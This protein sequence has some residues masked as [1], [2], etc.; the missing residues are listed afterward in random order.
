MSSDIE[1]LLANSEEIQKR[2]NPS[3]MDSSFVKSYLISGLLTVGVL[4]LAFMPVDLGF[5]KLYLLVLLVV[6]AAIVLKSEIQRNFIKYYITSQQVIEKRGIL[7]QTTESTMYENITD[8]KL[9]EAINER[10][11]DVGDIKV[12]TAG[13]DGATILLR[14]LKDPESYKRTIENNINNAKNGGSGGRGFGNG[15]G[16]NNGNGFGG[17]NSGNNGGGLDD[18]GL[19]DSSFDD[20]DF[21][22]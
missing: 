11:F 9:S 22:L 19:G 1:D 20:D 16:N 13:H 7:S 2:A 17:N 14:G 10:I 21:G 5:N 3:I 18:S 4:V 15:N 6:P 8:V 12:N